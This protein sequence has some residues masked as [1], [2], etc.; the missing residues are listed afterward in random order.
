MINE[1]NNETMQSFLCKSNM[2]R[3]G[4]PVEIAQ[5]VLFLACSMS[6]FITGQVLR[7]D[8]GI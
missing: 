4:Q 6:S 7:V 1:M 5:A 3:S 8:G 2:R